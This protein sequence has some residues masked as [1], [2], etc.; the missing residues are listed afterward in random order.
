VAWHE[1]GTKKVDLCLAVKLVKT[2]A[3]YTNYWSPLTCLVNKQEE[4]E[5]N[6]D[7]TSKID[8]AINAIAS[9]SPTNKTAAHWEQKMENRRW[10]KTSILD[11][12]ATSGV[13]PEKDEEAFK[14]RGMNSNKTFV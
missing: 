8:R 1:P 6:T 13:A 9:K 10:Q 14:E 11:T 12:G 3:N 4:E 7:K 5:N 2:P